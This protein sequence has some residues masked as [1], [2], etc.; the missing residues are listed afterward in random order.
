MARKLYILSVAAAAAAPEP[1]PE[2]KLEPEAPLTSDPAAEPLT[3][4]RPPRQRPAPTLIRPFVIRLIAAL[5]TGDRLTEVRRLRA[6]MRALQ[7]GKAGNG[8][9]EKEQVGAPTDGP[10]A[11]RGQVLTLI[12]QILDLLLPQQ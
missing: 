8:R 10:A 2:P 7:E 11:V 1:K 12:G 5:E 6:V 3:P 9:K 4:A